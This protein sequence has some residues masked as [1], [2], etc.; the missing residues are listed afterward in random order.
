MLS[1]DGVGCL[2]Y[3]EAVAEGYFNF[4]LGISQGAQYGYIF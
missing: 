3:D 1:V 4:C 2:S